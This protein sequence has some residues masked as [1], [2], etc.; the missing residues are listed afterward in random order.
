MKK[1]ILVV[2]CA[3]SLSTVVEAAE[4]ECKNKCQTQ[5]DVCAADCKV[6]NPLNEGAEKTCKKSCANNATKCK[7]SC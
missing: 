6:S 1:L 2:A 4:S 7:K 5:H 3:L